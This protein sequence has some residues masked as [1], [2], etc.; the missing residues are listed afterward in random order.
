MANTALA[1]RTAQEA[2]R[3]K[4]KDEWKGKKI[5]F[6]AAQF[7]QDHTFHDIAKL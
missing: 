5:K 1:L 4:K 3:L 2:R 6:V 7:S